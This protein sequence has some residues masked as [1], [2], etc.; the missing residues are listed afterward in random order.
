M[1]DAPETIEHH[2]PTAS[3]RCA[4]PA[5]RGERASVR[6]VVRKRHGAR[7]DLASKRSSS[8]IISPDVV[9]SITFLRSVPADYS[10]LSLTDAGPDVENTIRGRIRTWDAVVQNLQQFGFLRI[11]AA[12]LL[13]S[14]N[15]LGLTVS[16]TAF[17]ASAPANAFKASACGNES[18]LSPTN[19]AT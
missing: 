19:P 3:H 8:S 5:R 17:N 6:L 9:D 15:V 7:P 10:R 12:S 14:W 4:E 13:A 11:C 2:D 16:S 18:L 1:H